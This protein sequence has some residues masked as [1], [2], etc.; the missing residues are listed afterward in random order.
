MKGITVKYGANTPSLDLN[1]SS[2]DSNA[3]ELQYKP[4]TQGKTF[5]G[6][7]YKN[8]GAS[9]SAINP[10]DS[11]FRK[12][13]GNGR[14]LD[15]QFRYTLN[16]FYVESYYQQ[17]KGYYLSNPGKVMTNPFG[18][19]GEY[20]QNTGLKTEH[21]GVVAF[22]F[23]NPEKFHPRRAFELIE[24][25][26][27]GGGS[28]YY[29]LGVNTHKVRTSD[30][31]VPATS[32]NNYLRLE[33]L[34]TVKAYTLSLGAGGGYSLVF[35]EAW[36]LSGLFGL[37]LGNQW[38]EAKYTDKNETRSAA[39]IKTHVKG[40]LGYSGEKFLTGVIIQ[41]DSTPLMS[42]NSELMLSTTEATFVFGW[43]F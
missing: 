37:S 41:S 20:P 24:R 6:F 15:F 12:K 9:L 39:T 29:S 2:P 35:R 19:D 4:S 10:R 17:Y 5:I 36:I 7:D 43:R 3:K 38:L 18:A 27:E 23:Q 40:G 1:A 22:K 13:Y 42:K 32:T 11:E 28:W 33:D 26:G 34:R 21:Y 31:L 16:E 14:S 25:P 30:S 8:Y